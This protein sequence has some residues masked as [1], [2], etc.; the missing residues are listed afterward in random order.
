MVTLENVNNVNGVETSKR[1]EMSRTYGMWYKE[2]ATASDLV[3]WCDARIAVYNEWIK[4]CKELKQ[5]SQAQL[6]SGMSRAELEA[7]LAALDA[8]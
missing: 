2:G 1:A 8:Q 3:S 7:A 5:S 6:L 4:N